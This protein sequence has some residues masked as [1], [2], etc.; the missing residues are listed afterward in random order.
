MLVINTRININTKINANS[1]YN[2]AQD[3]LTIHHP[4]TWPQRLFDDTFAT[5]QPIHCTAIIDANGCGK[6]S[7]FKLLLEGISLVFTPKQWR[8]RLL[9]IIGLL[10]TMFKMAM[11]TGSVRISFSDLDNVI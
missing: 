5:I 7:L 9:K 3:H 1:G 4:T 8:R 2:S 11:T 6:S 10:A